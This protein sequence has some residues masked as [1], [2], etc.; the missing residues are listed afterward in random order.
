MIH[1]GIL[2]GIGSAVGALLRYGVYELT[3]VQEYPIAT[4][5]VNVIG[6]FVL[7]VVLFADM[8]EGVLTSSASASVARLR[9]TPHSPSIR[10][11]SGNGATSD[12]PSTAQC[13]TSLRRSPLSV[14][15]GYSCEIC[16]CYAHGQ[17]PA[18]IR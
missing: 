7:G 12:T 16:L 15:R 1:P 13:L 9:H 6:S 4:L 10:S 14:S 3:P 2:V 5:I 17:K 18:A 11:D 8:G